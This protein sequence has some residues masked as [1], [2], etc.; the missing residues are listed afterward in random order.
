[1]AGVNQLPDWTE[2][3][4]VQSWSVTENHHGNRGFH[5]R[6]YVN[7]RYKI[8]VYRE[9]DTGELFDL[10]ADPKETNN[11]WDDPECA[12]LKTKRLHAFLQATLPSEAV[13]MPPKNG[14][15]LPFVR[16]VGGQ[17]QLDLALL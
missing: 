3:R 17:S 10:E 6:T 12:G 4:E 8:T 9:W 7:R 2:G 5:L 1:M 14:H 15:I 13:S 16:F 11:V